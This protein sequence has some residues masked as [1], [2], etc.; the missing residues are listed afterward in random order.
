M[1]ALFSMI[2]LSMFI[3]QAMADTHGRW[4]DPLPTQKG[5]T[6]TPNFM[7]YVT[8]TNDTDRHIEVKILLDNN[9]VETAF[10]QMLKDGIS[11]TIKANGNMFWYEKTYPL[12]A[13]TTNDTFSIPL[14]DGRIDDYKVCVWF[15]KYDRDNGCANYSAKNN[16]TSQEIDMTY[17]LKYVHKDLQDEREE[18]ADQEEG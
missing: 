8:Y 5:G 15:D 18:L 11:F 10:K 3:G 6:S 9:I 14:T 16:V 17:Q 7:P 4:V 2:V 1:R 13:L 12:S